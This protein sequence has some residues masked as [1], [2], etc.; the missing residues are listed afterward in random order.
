M[1][2]DRFLELCNS[3]NEKPTPLAKKIGISP[4]LIRRWAEGASITSDTL[5]KLA[6][7][8]NVPTD[9]LLSDELEILN[10][11]HSNTE[12]AS[13][14]NT[15][16]VARSDNNDNDSNFAEALSVSYKA[17]KSHPGY[18]L[19]LVTGTRI[20]EKDLIK[21]NDYLG[22]VLSE[23]LDQ[24]S[25]LISDDDYKNNNSAIILIF[26]VLSKVSGSDDYKYMQFL[27]SKHI[28]RNLFMKGITLDVLHQKKLCTSKVKKIYE[29]IL[30][31]SDNNNLSGFNLSDIIN[32]SET[33]NISYD[34]IF[35]GKE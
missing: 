17:I 27:I 15:V 16:T 26:V 25:F 4:G 10:S 12:L 21:I 32:I 31:G 6:R 9:Y 33:F 30:G 3:V 35:T 18:M 28:A 5:V 29:S 34:Y 11:A 7:Y 14:T 23:L 1:F 2:Y 19:S 20:H 24:K 22:G 13:E 8:F